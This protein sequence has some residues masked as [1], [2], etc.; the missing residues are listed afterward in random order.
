MIGTYELRDDV[1]S[2]RASEER[3]NEEDIASTKPDGPARLQPVP[4]AIGVVEVVPKI[5]LL[6]IDPDLAQPLQLLT[7]SHRPRA[8]ILTVESVGDHQHL[9]AFP[10]EAQEGLRVVPEAE[11]REVHAHEQQAAP[12]PP[13][14][15]RTPRPDAS[16]H[17]A[18]TSCPVD[19]SSVR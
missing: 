4:N 10:E 17:S 11:R 16:V 15:F 18:C 7:D 2:A 13:T 8:W 1:V 14:A 3:S 19:A 9:S 6:A 5:Q 12:R